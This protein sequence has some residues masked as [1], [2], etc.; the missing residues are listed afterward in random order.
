M[1]EN[2]F[3]CNTLLAIEKYQI[4]LDCLS[5]ILDFFQCFFFF[6]LDE[7]IGSYALRIKPEFNTIPEKRLKLYRDIESVLQA[8]NY[9][10][11]SRKLISVTEF[12]S[13]KS[14][15]ILRNI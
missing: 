4:S 1:Y 15:Q 2:L 10:E 11:F 5:L 14:S 13:L 7:P 6:F 3:F 12:H 9:M 8:D